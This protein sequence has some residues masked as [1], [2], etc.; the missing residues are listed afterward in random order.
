MAFRLQISL[1]QPF[2][3]SLRVLSGANINV[4]TPY[5]IEIN[6][7]TFFHRRAMS[8]PDALAW[9]AES[10]G[11]TRWLNDVTSVAEP[12]PA[13]Y[14]VGVQG[15][16]LVK[17]NGGGWTPADSITLNEVVR[18]SLKSA[19]PI[20]FEPF[21]EA[22]RSGAAILVDETSNS[23]VAAVLFQSANGN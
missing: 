11:T 4:N 16:V 20:I 9:R 22:G 8:S 10:S 17:T 3:S 18:A 15:T 23:T 19:E 12:V 1:G 7:F 5:S 2:A 21:A 14:A 6:D 13:W